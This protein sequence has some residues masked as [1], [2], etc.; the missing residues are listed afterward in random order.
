MTNQSLKPLPNLQNE[1][2]FEDFISENDLFVEPYKD[3]W[4]KILGTA[5]YA[6]QVVADF[7]LISFIRYERGGYAGL[8]CTD[9]N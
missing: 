5:F 2:I 4:I 6:V 3:L 7:T 1:A 8:C 9:L